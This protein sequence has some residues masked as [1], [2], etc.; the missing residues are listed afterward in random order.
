MVHRTST[1]RL[2]PGK[3]RPARRIHHVQDDDERPASGFKTMDR[4][5]IGFLLRSAQFTNAT[6]TAGQRT[7]PIPMSGER[8]CGSPA[9]NRW[10]VRRRTMGAAAVWHVL[11]S[12]GDTC[13]ECD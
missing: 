6:S 11:D 1:I 12:V 13:P 9:K 8:R 10:R 4:R 7:G 3:Q 2:H 5:A